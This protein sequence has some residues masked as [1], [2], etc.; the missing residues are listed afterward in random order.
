MGANDTELREVGSYLCMFYSFDKVLINNTPLL[1]VHPFDFPP[2]TAE[3]KRK[4]STA[5][6]SISKQIRCFAD[7]AFTE[8]VWTNNTSLRKI[9]ESQEEE[10]YLSTI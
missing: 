7:A 8:A 5:T 2:S 10:A 3:S 9:N 6:V 4:T 1:P